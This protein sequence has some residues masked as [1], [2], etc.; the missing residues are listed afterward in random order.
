MNLRIAA[1]LFLLV[2]PN[3]S[4]RQPDCNVAPLDERHFAVTVR[5]SD[6]VVV[7]EVVKVHRS[8]GF[9]SGVLASSQRVTYR[10]REVLKGSVPTGEIEVGHYVVHCSQ[11]ADVDQPQ[12]SPRLFSPGRSV[13]LLL[14]S[15]APGSCQGLREQGNPVA[16]WCCRDENYGAREA[17]DQIVGRVREILARS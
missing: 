10:V 6:Y 14:S 15:N 8:L 7:A 12:L 1:L 4:A 17:T 13:L 11:T 5:S 2:A 9:W 16:S 3:A